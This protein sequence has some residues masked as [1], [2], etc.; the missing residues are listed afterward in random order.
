[1]L[2]QRLHSEQDDLMQKLAG[3]EWDD[4]VEKQL[5]DAI[6]EAIDDFGADFDEEGDPLEEGESDRAKSEDKRSKSS[7]DSGDGD[8]DDD[9]DEESEG[10]EDKSAAPVG[11]G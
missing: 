3:G 10:S 6:A 7:G 4:D 8:S 1:M 9:G 2:L 5:G 11:G